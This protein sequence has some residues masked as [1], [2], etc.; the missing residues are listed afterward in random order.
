MGR[1]SSS[2]RHDLISGGAGRPPLASGLSMLSIVGADLGLRGIFFRF[3]WSLPSS[4]AGMLGLFAGEKGR[5][6]K[7]RGE[8][9]MLYKPTKAAAPKSYVCPQQGAVHIDD[10]GH[11]HRCC[12]LHPVWTVF[13]RF[14][15]GSPR[16]CEVEIQNCGAWFRSITSCEGGIASPH[17]LP[18]CLLP[19]RPT[20]TLARS[21]SR[22]TRPC[23]AETN[24]PSA[25]RNVCN[26]TQTQ[27]SLVS[28]G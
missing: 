14:S 23:L 15:R 1:P 5:E 16:A 8:I 24:R 22:C 26:E 3:G 17:S 11:P 28:T 21:L 4:V 2:Q 12:G 25:V 6:S 9:Q 13:V 7:K 10:L 19:V 20:T 27:G 18:T